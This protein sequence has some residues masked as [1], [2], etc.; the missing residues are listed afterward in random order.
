MRSTLYQKRSILLAGTGVWKISYVAC[1]LSSIKLSEKIY[2]SFKPFVLLQ[3]HLL[4]CKHG[5]CDI[6]VTLYKVSVT[7]SSA[8]SK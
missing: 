8:L 3:S 1:W 5:F 2:T 6:S 7:L 4:L